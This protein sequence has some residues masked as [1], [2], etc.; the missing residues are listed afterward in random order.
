[1]WDGWWWVYVVV[2]MSVWRGRR[3]GKGEER[4]GNGETRVKKNEGNRAVVRVWIYRQYSEW[5]G[6]WWGISSEG[7]SV[8]L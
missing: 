8:L 1:M 2:L 4:E 5:W 6:G 3:N 7:N